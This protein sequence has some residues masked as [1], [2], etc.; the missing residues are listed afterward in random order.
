MKL[1][2][3]IIPVLIQI[4]PGVHVNRNDVP[5]LKKR[6]LRRWQPRIRARAKK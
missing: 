4:M 1:R 6:V 2:G 3:P 5:G